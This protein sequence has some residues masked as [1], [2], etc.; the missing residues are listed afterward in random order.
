MDPMGG[1]TFRQSSG[2]AVRRSGSPPWHV[3][4]LECADGSF[5]TGV[6]RDPE[7][8]LQQHNGKRGA[9]YTR[10]RGPVRLVYVERAADRSAALRREWAIKQL[11]REEKLG[12]IMAK[13]S[14]GKSRTVEDSERFS[15]IRPAAIRFLSG[16]KKRNTKPWFEA[17]RAVY[18]TEIRGPLKALVEE[19][20]VLLARV[21][22]EIVGD[23]RRSIFRIHRDV[24]FSRDK[25]P[26]KTNAACWFYHHDAGRAV[27]GESQGGAGFYFHFSPTE[28]FLGGGIWMPPRESLNRLR[29]AIADD[30][31]GFEKIVLAP[32]FKRRFGK[33]D[34][35]AM[36]K[37]MPRG[38]SEEHP[39]AKWLR[40]QSFTTGRELSRRELHSPRLPQQL[41]RDYGA[42]TPFIR[43]LNGALGYRALGR[44]V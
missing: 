29:E 17:N 11:H 10:A 20:D 44:R 16:L 14:S 25:S 32:A 22:P 19:V 18:E 13:A 26:Y 30:P 41:A 40:F 15:S 27:G 43:W 2:Q 34:E 6:A 21:A 7:Q 42:L 12:L 35:E 31:K 4:I 24:R 1:Q 9:A 23:P 39:A 8:R 36:L 28:V 3:Y 5:Y 33:M 37:R 38:Y